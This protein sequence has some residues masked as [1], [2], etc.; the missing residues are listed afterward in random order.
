MDTPADRDLVLRVR[1]GET[2]AYGALVRRHQQ[3]VFN[4][5]CRI[6][7]NAADAEDLAQDAFVRAYDK[8]ATFDIDRDFGPWVRRIA[9]NLSINALKRRQPGFPLDEERDTLPPETQPEHALDQTLQAEHLHAA[10]ARLPPHY[11]A[12]IELRHFHDMNYDEIAAALRLPLNTA[13][14]HLFRARKLLA[15]LLHE[16]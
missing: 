2:D 5:C 9:A 10:L 4:V 13:K 12:A 1:R 15:D 16:P 6:L 8:L 3:S 14:S 7:H 11:R